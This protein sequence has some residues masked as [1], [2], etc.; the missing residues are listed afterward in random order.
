MHGAG[1][2]MEK[3]CSLIQVHY[4]GSLI[5]EWKYC[6]CFWAQ[7]FM[8]PTWS[9]FGEHLEKWTHEVVSNSIYLLKKKTQKF[10]YCIL[11]CVEHRSTAI[12]QETFPHFPTEKN[13][14]VSMPVS[15][16]RTA[17]WLPLI[18][19]QSLYSFC[20]S[21]EHGG[22]IWCPVKSVKNCQM[23]KLLLFLIGWLATILFDLQ[24]LQAQS[25]DKNGKALM[26]N[27]T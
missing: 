7:A 27:E 2:Q 17:V 5:A 6:C 26:R 12:Y 23:M 19:W 24:F 14:H 20:F 4:V 3:M 10:I 25:A 16:D 1:L 22:E 13:L 15:A 18:V 21:G 9:F 8:E 11:G